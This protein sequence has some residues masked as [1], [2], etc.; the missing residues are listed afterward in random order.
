MSAPRFFAD[1]GKRR[2]LDLMIIQGLNNKQLAE[3]F[4]CCD[5]TIRHEKRKNPRESLPA[6]EKRR[7]V[8]EAENQRLR[9][10]IKKL[11]ADRAVLRAQLVELGATPA[12]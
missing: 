2:E 12:V 7:R 8:L 3:H 5:K 10:G 11:S 6:E 4:G 9:R 1:L